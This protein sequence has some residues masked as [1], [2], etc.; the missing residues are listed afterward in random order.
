M[1]QMI[2]VT[3][4]RNDVQW[5][6]AASL[7]TPEPWVAEAACAEIDPEWGFPEKG[8]SPEPA[9]AICLACPVMDEC[10]AFAL[11]TGQT[12]GVWGGKTE[13][14]LAK[15]RRTAAAA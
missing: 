9:R 7:I 10:L 12:S 14:Q 11:R 8:Y 13:R 4:V 6:G 2:P 5:S 1:D 15:L 3:H